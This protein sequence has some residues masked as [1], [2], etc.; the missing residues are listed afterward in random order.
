MVG[1]V[2]EETRIHVAHYSDTRDRKYGRLAKRTNLTARMIPNKNP[3]LER[4]PLIQQRPKIHTMLRLLK[5]SL[6]CQ[7]KSSQ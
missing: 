7:V 4:Q 6:G 3:I 2:K 5:T 1:V